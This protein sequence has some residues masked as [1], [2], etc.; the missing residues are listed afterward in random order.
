MTEF[1]KVLQECLRDLEQGVANVD[2][3]L[4]RH[5]EYAGQLEPV[6]LASMY[7]KRAGE[8]SVS[9]A[10]KV[11][12]R[13]RLIQGMQTHPRKPA[14][15]GLIFMRLVV[16][17][18]AVLLALLATGT[19][20]AQN[21][22][23][24][25]T[26]YGWKLASENAWRA[27][28][29]DPVETDLAIAERRVDELVVVK[30]DPALR[31]QTLDAYVETVARLRS[32]AGTGNDAQITRRLDSQIERLKKLGILLSQADPNTL[33]SDEPMPVPTATSTATPVPVSQTPQSGPT[34]L[35]Q[36]TPTVE[37]PPAIVPTVEIPPELIPT[38]E[39]PPPIR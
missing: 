28:S 4:V 5:P 14:R 25:D 11:R 38:I 1:E 23:P 6:L 8:A 21:T 29:S 16:G 30:D 17:L 10:F 35:P 31:A 20:Y 22:L 39:V 12:V 27:V 15:S 7:L 3:C 26:F 36:V 34:D 33:P 2:E 13:A 37:F 18:S 9:D 32:Q 19:A 24:G